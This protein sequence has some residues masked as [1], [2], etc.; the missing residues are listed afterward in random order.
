V[1]LPQKTPPEATQPLAREKSR[2]ISDDIFAKPLCNCSLLWSQQHG[3]RR[4]VIK[5]LP[6]RVSYWNGW[7]EEISHHLRRFFFRGTKWYIY[8]VESVPWS[9]RHGSRQPIYM[10]TCLIGHVAEIGLGMIS[11]VRTNCDRFYECEVF[12]HP[13]CC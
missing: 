9:Q 6:N 11:F 2:I 3:N 10:E 4:Q 7:G 1:L 8:V 12:P 5:N 13:R